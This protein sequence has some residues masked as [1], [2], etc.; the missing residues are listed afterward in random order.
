[1]HKAIKRSED[2][3]S[4]A[5]DALVFI[6]GDDE[7]LPRFLALTGIQVEQIREAAEEPGF[8]AGVL[9]FLLAHEPSLLKFSEHSGHAPESVEY[10]FRKLSAGEDRIEN[11]I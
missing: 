10:A 2:I 4:I 6:A 7:L 8:L 11:S 9:Q 1:M 5:I 3:D